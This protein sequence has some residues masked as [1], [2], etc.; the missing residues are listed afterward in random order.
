MALS[1]TKHLTGNGRDEE[2]IMKTR[3]VWS[4]LKGFIVIKYRGRRRRGGGGDCWSGERRGRSGQIQRLSQSLGSRDKS[5]ALGE[6][7]GSVPSTC[8][9]ETRET[10]AFFPMPSSERRKLVTQNSELDRHTF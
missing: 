3:C 2:A 7:G 5:L 6:N 4:H 1:K 9:R 8:V 10:R